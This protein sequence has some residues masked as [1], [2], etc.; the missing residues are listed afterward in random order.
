[1]RI[2]RALSL[3]AA[4]VANGGGPAQDEVR[5]LLSQADAVASR[6][7]NPHA[8]GLARGVRGLALHQA[9]K[10]AQSVDL[11]DEADAIF[12]ERCAGVPW[13]RASVRAFALWDL[14]FLGDLRE[15]ARRTPL[16]L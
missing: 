12:R 10:W 2:A 9:G 5:E 7:G 14:W 15:F 1:Y 11:L 4:F 8:L 16:Y 3:E 6:V 13:E